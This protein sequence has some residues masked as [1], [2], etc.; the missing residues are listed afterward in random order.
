[1]N[2]ENKRDLSISMLRANVLALF[3]MIPVAILQFS[4]F[5]LWNG[6][7]EASVTLNL[8]NML[9]FALIVAAS[10]VAHEFIH[11]LAWVVFGKKPFSAVQ[12]G[13]QWKVLTPFAHLKEPIEVHGYRVGGFMP[14][15]ILG[16]LPFLL[17]LILGNGGLL[18]FGVLQTAAASGDWLI[19]WLLRKVKSG[20]M[21]ED[22]PS[23]AGCYVYDYV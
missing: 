20:T 17:S 21:V 5:A 10:I 23:R 18:W 19:L 7:G 3:I 4:L 8:L 14:G 15:F 13:V 9:I 16:I 2:T 6:D 11:G 1:M 22:H 12:F